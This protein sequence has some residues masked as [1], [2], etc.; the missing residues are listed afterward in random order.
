MPL[1]YYNAS[2]NKTNLKKKREALIVVY[3]LAMRLLSIVIG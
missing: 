3:V 1:L 2:P